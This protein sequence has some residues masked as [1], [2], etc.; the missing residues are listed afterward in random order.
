MKR[1]IQRGES[2]LAS[3]QVLKCSPQPGT[4]REVH[5]GI[6]RREEGGERG[7][8]EERSGSQKERDQASQ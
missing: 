2:N 4:P 1:G 7:D 8:Q 6:W 5:R 3:N